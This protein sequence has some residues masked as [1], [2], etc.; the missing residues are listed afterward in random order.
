[1]KR[2]IWIILFGILAGRPANGSEAPPNIVLIISDDQGWADYGFMGHETIQTPHLDRLAAESLFYPR[3]YVPASLCCPSLASIITGLYPHQHGITGNEPPIPEGVRGGDR[4]ADPEY[5]RRVREM[6]SLIDRVPTLPRLLAGRGYTSFQSGKWWLG[7]YRRGG[8]THGM[9]HGDPDRGGRHGDEGLRIGREGMEPIFDFIE[10]T[11]GQP[12]FLWYAPFL[13]HR[14]HNPPERFL[15]RYLAKTDSP[16]VARYWAMCTWFDET[17]GALIDYL[18]RHGLRENTL[19]VYVADNGWIQRRDGSGYAHRSK[20]SPY[21]GG[22]RTP[23]L[24]RWPGHVVPGREETPVSSVDIAPTIL[25]ACG[26]DVPAELPGL[27]LLDIDR[28]RRRTAIFG[29]VYLHNAVDLHDPA[30][31]LTYRWMIAN[32]RWKLIVPHVENVLDRAKERGAGEVEL[33]DLRADPSE[34]RNLAADRPERILDMKARLDAWW[35]AT[36]GK[37]GP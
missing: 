10:G 6:I 20:R 18:D 21:D 9:T 36:R 32:S 22:I 27:N 37:Q 13:P 5:Q 19:V 1:M 35:P 31:N 28:V 34:T 12:F 29:D 11:E 24:I 8:F 2:I 14:P 15:E 7:D 4:Y 26:L 16:H 23:V 25:A 3:G 33:Y 30:A 17:C